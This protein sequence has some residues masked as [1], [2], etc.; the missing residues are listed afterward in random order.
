MMFNNLRELLDDYSAITPYHFGRNLYK[1][2]DCGPW[3][4][5]LLRDG[6]EVYYRD[7]KAS[8]LLW[9]DDCIG[10]KIGSI[11]EGSDAEIGPET[12]FF[13]FTSERLDNVVQEINDEASY[14]WELANCPEDEDE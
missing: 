4:A 13:P 7:E 6:S 3:T 11:V 12:L 14:E 1:Y 2:T 5:F 8:S 9:G 10:I